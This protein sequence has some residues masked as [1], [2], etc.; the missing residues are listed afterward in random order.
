MTDW[1]C[2]TRGLLSVS[3]YAVKS[4]R[5]QSVTDWLLEPGADSVQLRRV[6]RGGVAFLWEKL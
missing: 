6:W 5:Y 3:D 1:R 4:L 2:Y